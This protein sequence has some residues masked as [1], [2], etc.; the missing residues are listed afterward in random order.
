[1]SNPLNACQLTYN[2]H[3]ASWKVTSASS[4]STKLS[5][6]CNPAWSIEL[7][8][9]HDQV[10][11]NVPKSTVGY[12]GVHPYS[13]NPKKFGVHIED[14]EPDHLEAICILSMVLASF[15]AFEG[16]VE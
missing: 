2:S 7:T 15:L 6:K 10:W 1:M 4:R 13:T 8:P 9:F 14:V 11:A 5:K 3:R 16:L 12:F